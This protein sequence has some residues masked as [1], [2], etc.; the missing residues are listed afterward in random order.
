MPAH[1]ARDENKRH[2]IAVRRIRTT[3]TES[4]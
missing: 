4:R 1:F 2:V 3:A